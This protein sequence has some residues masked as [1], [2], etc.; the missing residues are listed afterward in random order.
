[1]RP[2]PGKDIQAKGLIHFPGLYSVVSR[3]YRSMIPEEAAILSLAP[4]SRSVT[5]WFRWTLETGYDSVRNLLR[6]PFPV[7]IHESKAV[8]SG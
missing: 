2:P 6:W 8:M 3:R 4:F 1:M 7:G 5:L